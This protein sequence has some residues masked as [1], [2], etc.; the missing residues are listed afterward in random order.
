MSFWIT[1]DDC[2]GL[3]YLRRA[4]FLAQ[5]MI[6]S[7]PELEGKEVEEVRHWL[8]STRIIEW[9]W[10]FVAVNEIA[11]LSSDPV[12]VLDIGCDPIFA[13]I[14]LTIPNVHVTM[15][16]TWVDADH[17]GF[18]QF[19]NERVT[20]EKFFEKYKDR[21]RMELVSPHEEVCSPLGSYTEVFDIVT[22]ISVCEHLPGDM[23]KGWAEW[24][25]SRLKEDGKYLITFDWLTG[26]GFEVD[27]HKQDLTMQNKPMP[28]LMRGKPGPW[29]EQLPEGT[30]F[31]G[32]FYVTSDMERGEKSYHQ[33]YVWGEEMTKEGAACLQC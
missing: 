33:F 3:N 17:F 19:G 13:G 11:L 31:E 4:D 28:E 14:L 7:F 15:H 23:Y 18:F 9:S 32:N 5:K 2:Q 6:E 26:E 8:H 24:S 20:P 29:D 22:N 27:G 21:V 16:R 30:P 10:A 12:Y 25:W 1:R